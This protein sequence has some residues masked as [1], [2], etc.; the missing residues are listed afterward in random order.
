[1]ADTSETT[2][3]YTHKFLT[4]DKIRLFLGVRRD[5]IVCYFS[6]V[7]TIQKSWVNEAQL[8]SYEAVSY[9]WEIRMILGRLCVMGPASRFQAP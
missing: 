7:S 9:V 6:V 4:T 5:E 8:A 3:T 2:P 1:M